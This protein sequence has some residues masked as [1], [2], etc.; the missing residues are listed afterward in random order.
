MVVKIPFSVYE[1]IEEIRMSNLVDMND[2]IEVENV[3]HRLG[4]TVA[5]E[6]IQN[7]QELYF[8]GLMEGFEIK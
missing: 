3:C 7:N 5:V 8:K 2:I 6:W 4:F 1:G